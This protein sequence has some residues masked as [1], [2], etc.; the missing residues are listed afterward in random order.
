MSSKV[1]YLEDKKLATP[2]KW[3]TSNIAYETMMGSVAYGVSDVGS[4]IDIYGFTIPK[5][6]DIFP[7]LRGE[8]IG[9][10]SKQNKFEQYIQHHITDVSSQKIYD[11]TI[12]SIVKYFNLLMQGNPNI[13]DSIFTPQTC[14]THMTQVGNLVRE[15]RKLFL[16]KGCFKKFKGYAFSQMH[17]MGSKNPKEGSKRKKIRDKFGYD[18]KFALHLVR[19]LSEA[20]MIFLEGDLDL[21]ANK[22]QLKSIRR[23]EYTKNDVLKWAS[24]KER[25]LEELYL[26]SEL[27]N[28]APENKIKSLLLKCLE[29]HYG[30]LEKCIIQNEAEIKLQKIRTIL[31]E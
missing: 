8:I 28:K 12:F 23:G 7:H 14:V 11:I 13:I 4:D 22:E 1:K 31:D 16:H 17:K 21:Q 26:K 2:P 10:G 5:K 15:N 9:F 18:L 25:H 20:E 29:Q 3:L 24:D 30:S 27:P 6:E 19:L